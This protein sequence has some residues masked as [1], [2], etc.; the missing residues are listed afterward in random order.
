[1]PASYGASSYCWPVIGVVRCYLE[2]DD[3]LPEDQRPPD[4]PTVVEYW[5]SEVRAAVRSW[6][7]KGFRVLM[8]AL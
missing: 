3:R 5:P 1:M 2:P 7:R 4:W 8:V 6:R